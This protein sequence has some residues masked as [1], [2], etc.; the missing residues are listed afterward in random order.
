MMLVTVC[1]PEHT[2]GNREKAPQRAHCTLWDA[3]VSLDTV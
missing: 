2:Y 3:F 1:A